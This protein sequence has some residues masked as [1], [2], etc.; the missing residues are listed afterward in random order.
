MRVSYVCWILMFGTLSNLLSASWGFTADLTQ[1]KGVIFS[2]KETEQFAAKALKGEILG[3]YWTPT[4]AEIKRA[5]LALTTYIG[6]FGKNRSTSLTNELG[7]YRLQYLGYTDRNEKYVFI[8]GLC[9]EFWQT[10]GVWKTEPVVVFDGGD[11][12]FRARYRVL[13]SKIVRFEVNGDS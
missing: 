7:D 11:C 2:E 10:N 4:G 5:R 8:N 3:P 9:K 13:D 6:R 1:E 12:Y